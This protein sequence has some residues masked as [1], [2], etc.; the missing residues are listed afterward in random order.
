MCV[1]IHLKVIHHCTIKGL[2]ESRCG[3]NTLPPRHYVSRTVVRAAGNRQAQAAAFNTE[4]SFM[5]LCLELEIQA[6]LRALATGSDLD[7]S[8]V[9]GDVGH[10]RL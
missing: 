4:K 7:T 5:I 1:P 3:V 2:Q 8:Q 9:Q 6:S 10:P